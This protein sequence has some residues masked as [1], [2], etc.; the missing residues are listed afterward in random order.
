[1]VWPQYGTGIASNQGPGHYGE[2]D[3][4]HMD[5]IRADLIAYGYL[6]VDRIYDPSASAAMV[7]N[8][9]NEGR[10]IVNYCGHGSTTSWGTTGF[11]NSHVNVLVNDSML[12]F[13]CSVACSNGNFTST[14]CFA[15]AWLRAIHDGQPT[16]AIACY[17]SKIGQAWDPPMYAQD[18]AVDLLVADE[19]RTIG[20][21]WFN[22]S[23]LMMDIMG[24]SGVN[25]FLNWTIFGDPSLAVRTKQA[26]NLSVADTGVL[27]IGQDTYEVT[28][29]GIEGAL[30][31][32]YGNGVLY[33]SAVTGAGGMAQI[34]MDD[35]PT[36]VMTLTLTVTAY[37]KVTHQSEVPVLPPEGPYLVFETCSVLDETGDDDGILDGGEAVGLEVVLENVGVDETTGVTALLTTEDEYVTVTV[38]DAAYP[39][40]PAGAI[41]GCLTPFALEVAGN[42][43]DGHVVQM[44]L[45]AS[46]TGGIWTVNFSLPVQAPVLETAGVAVDD[47]PPGGDGSG[48]ADA[49]E[50]IALTVNLA[51]V[52]HSA[53]G[54]L[55]GWLE[56]ADVNVTVSD[57]DGSCEGVPI[58]GVGELSG[59][60]VEIGPDCPEPSNLLFFLYITGEDGFLTTLVFEL[61][62]GGWFDDL[63][64]DRGWTIG[65]TG[66]DATSGIWERVDPIGT[67]Y[68]GH[69]IQMDADHT[70][71]P[72]VSC[73]VTGNGSAG[74]SAGEND[75]DGGRTTL[76]TPVYDLSDA[77]S[78]T[79]S[80]W[81]W[82]TNSWGN[83][84]DSDWWD[85]EV[86]NDGVA[87]VSLEHTQET[88]AVWVEKIFELAGYIEL[89]D[90]VQIRFV[91]ADEGDAS[92]VEAGIDDFWLDV[93]HPSSTAVGDDDRGLPARLAL[94]AN[95]PNPF[96]PKTTISFALPRAVAVELAIFDLK[97]RKVVTLV[98]EEL[99]AG[100]YELPWFGHDDN[101]RQVASGIYFYRLSADEEVLTRK[102]TLLK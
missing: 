90:H 28:V 63:E 45:T 89:T 86:T 7:T 59:F 10:G 22:G 33:G 81:R 80:Y 88:A 42:V 73:Y 4:E 61:P 65:F 84:P 35:P 20:G 48:D 17:M 77:T 58:D 78:A 91:A 64:S 70:S 100:N 23:C 62:V 31:A 87:W 94:N 95:F 5:L 71:D 24:A 102:M 43:P 57:P 6:G 11:S 36:D 67:E 38:S 79:I 82:Y 19:M 13:I 99:P 1:M 16:G 98:N 92:L 25:E 27:L 18:E 101:D 96:N 69:V 26:E 66:D 56:S 44:T 68:N 30:C 32:L 14:T 52:G 40:I 2:Y 3:D 29:A 41:A 83:N 12:P 9:L 49:G 60:T 75:V 39:D 72:G 8:A 76:C 97:G 37:N 54:G 74:G 93:V 15:E 47:D 34:V 55:T 53:A 46:G 51:N 50:T 85:V 21:L